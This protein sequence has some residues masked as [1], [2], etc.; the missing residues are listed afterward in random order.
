M[1]VKDTVETG[2]SFVHELFPALEV[3]TL[4]RPTVMKALSSALCKQ[5]ADVMVDLVA[6]CARVLILTGLERAF[7]AGAVTY[8]WRFIAIFI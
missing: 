5:C 7:Y 3:V 4:N 8:N 2:V 6:I 1:A